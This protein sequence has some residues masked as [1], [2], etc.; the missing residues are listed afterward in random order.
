[1]FQVPG[2]QIR[3][4]ILGSGRIT[5]TGLAP[6]I[7]SDPRNVLVAT[8]S[9]DLA[10][11][12]RQAD[13][14]G[15]ENAHGSYEDLLADPAVDI[16][17]NPLPNSLH[18]E[19]TI[20]A[21]E[22]G[23]HVL[24]EKPMAL[25]A[26]DVRAMADAAVAADRLLIEGFMW[27]YH[28]RVAHVQQLAREELGPLRL[29]RVAYTYDLWANYAGDRAAAAGDIRLNPDLGGGAL[30]DIG[31]YTISGLRAYAGGKAVSV[32]SRLLSEHSGVDMRFSGE[33][34]F[35][36]GVLG[37]FY[38]AM[39]VPGGAVVDLTGD[40]G[41]VRLPNAFRTSSDWGDV[42]IQRL[43]QP[44]GMTVERLPFEDQFELEVASI[45]RVLLDND[46]PLITL[47]DSIGNAELMDAI[48]SSWRH[49]VIT[50]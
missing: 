16:V 6:A 50:L 1:M 29:V 13:L 24:C 32:S 4:G 10:A 11:A 15:A 49:G 28:P 47:E 42:I 2:E 26:A 30:G 48:R 25:S 43:D 8:S 12:R 36:N 45:S 35:D 44:G 38:C 22:A 14:L 37:Q 21:L 5:E 34:L 31:S 19:W 39:D 3:W 33:V 23:K 18:R 27:R 9:R 20:K 40:R 46:E 41:R 17:Y 7:E